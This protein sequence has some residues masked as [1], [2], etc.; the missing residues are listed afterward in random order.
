[1]ALEPKYGTRGAPTPKSLATFLRE[2]CAYAFGRSVPKKKRSGA[3]YRE[4]N[5]TGD[6]TISITG[7]RPLERGKSRGG[8]GYTFDVFAFDNRNARTN[9][10]CVFIVDE[11]LNVYISEEEG[12]VPRELLTCATSGW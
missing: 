10:L 3:Y 11:D 9:W 5:L 8:G 7:V 12:V 6:E 2:R 1:M 4:M